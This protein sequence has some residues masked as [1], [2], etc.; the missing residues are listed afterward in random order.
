[1]TPASAETAAE[2]IDAQIQRNYKLTLINYVALEKLQ[3]A[4][5][6]FSG[7]PALFGVSAAEVQAKRDELAQRLKAVPAEL[8]PYVLA[9]YANPVL[10]KAKHK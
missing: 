10:S 1:M 2:L 5:M 4:F 6:D 8:H 7:L 9:M 3:P